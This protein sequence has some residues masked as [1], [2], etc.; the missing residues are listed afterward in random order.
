MLHIPVNNVYLSHA[1]TIQM[2]KFL[3]AHSLVS[4]TSITVI[5]MKEILISITPQ[6][7]FL[8]MKFY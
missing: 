1:S 4:H 6:E 5:S 3:C 8:S 7:I 2:A